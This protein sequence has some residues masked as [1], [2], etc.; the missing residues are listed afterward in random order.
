[1]GATEPVPPAECSREVGRRPPRTASPRGLYGTQRSDNWGGLEGGFLPEA[2]AY[3]TRHASK[4]LT[5]LRYRA[6]WRTACSPGGAA[7]HSAPSLE[8]REARRFR[9]C[10]RRHAGRRRT[11][12]VLPHPQRWRRL[13]DAGKRQSRP[14][15]P[16]PP[17]PVHCRFSSSQTGKTRATGCATARIESPEVG[18]G[19][20]GRSPGT[21]FE[22]CAS[23]MAAAHVTRRTATRK[24][25]PRRP[26]T[27]KKGGC[28]AVAEIDTGSTDAQRPPPPVQSPQANRQTRTVKST[29]TAGCPCNTFQ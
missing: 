13:T 6:R 5:N 3:F 16:P 11:W 14:C 17:S 21:V 29:G 23:G 4:R 24:Q 27:V 9:Q 8:G 28:T 20:R 12:P 25:W 18:R 2:S 10:R 19:V 15:P 1:V 7:A 22:G 26:S